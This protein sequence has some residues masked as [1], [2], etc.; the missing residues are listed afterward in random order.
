MDSKWFERSPGKGETD[1]SQG[2]DLGLMEQLRGELPK[3]Q[4]MSYLKGS[5]LET[6]FID[7]SEP[8][9][10]TE[11]FQEPGILPIVRL[12]VL[13]SI[14]EKFNSLQTWE[15]VVMEVL[16]DSFFARLVDLTESNPDEEAEFPLEEVSEEDRKL[17]KPSAVFYWNIGYHDSRSGQRTRASVIR[18]RR[19]PAW[20][21]KEIETAKREAR[22]LR[23]IIGWK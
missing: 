21:S 18:F 3:P 11:S 22:D 14:K 19:L 17:V 10:E 6:S 1:S 13:P 4:V 15:G 20:T 8:P 16:E 9:R 23:E 2:P 7:P 12:P 5:P